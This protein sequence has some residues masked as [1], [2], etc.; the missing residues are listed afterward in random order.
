VITKPRELGGHSPRWAAK[1]EK[2]K[3][4]L[5]LIVLRKI[6][7]TDNMC[8]ENQN[9]YPMFKIVFPENRAVYGLT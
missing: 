4:N 5:R 2:I 9:T 8:R 7:V 6:N 1:P 3:I